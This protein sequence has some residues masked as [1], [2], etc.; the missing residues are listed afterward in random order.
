MLVG[1]DIKLRILVQSIPCVQCVHALNKPKS[2]NLVMHLRRLVI[3]LSTKHE[4]VLCEA[5]TVL[6][7]TKLLTNFFLT[8]KLRRTEA[9]R[10]GEI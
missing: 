3:Q 10:P 7:K 8:R 1:S 9:K 5:T 4:I 2:N 6:T